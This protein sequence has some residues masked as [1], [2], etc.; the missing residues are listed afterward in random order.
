MKYG[1][2]RVWG[3]IG[4]GLAALLS[5]IAVNM[6]TKDDD[7]S[8]VPALVIMLFFSGLDL[9][10][11]KW[12]KLPKLS[13][14]DDILHDVKMLIKDGP[15]AIFLVFATLAGIFDSFI[16]YYMFWHLEEVATVTG[17]M[18]SIK[19]IE[20]IVVAAECLGGE[21]I[22]FL[23]S[24][25]IL[26]K[27][28]YVHCLTFCFLMY[29]L[30]LALISM[31]TNPWWLVPIELFMQGPSYALCYTCIVAYAS[32]IAPPGASATVQGLVAG[33]D[34]GV[35]ECNGTAKFKFEFY[36]VFFSGFALGSLIGGQMFARL[37]G[38]NSFRIFA[39][40][41][42]VTCVFHIILRPASKHE[43]QKGRA[44][45]EVPPEQTKPNES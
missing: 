37:G 45:Y 27:I 11:V 6:F 31:I 41:A 10:S 30:R 18:G 17:H 28:G 5:G 36:L 16:I 8:L 2:Q 19:L 26:K 39:C 43:T 4:F 23:I 9:M 12:L 7:K 32:A 15:I 44:S 35:G 38:R 13:G 14:T 34:D 21:I 1:H 22:F 42:L 25:K 20:G 29:S 24:G 3:T 40:G 33:M